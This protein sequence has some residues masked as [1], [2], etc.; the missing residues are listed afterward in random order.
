MTSAAAR[1]VRGKIARAIATELG[2]GAQQDGPVRVSAPADR[3]PWPGRMRSRS[4][5]KRIHEVASRLIIE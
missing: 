5:R 3:L 4:S 1:A 2:V